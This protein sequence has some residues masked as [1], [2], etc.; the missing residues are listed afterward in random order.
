MQNILWLWS[1]CVSTDLSHILCSLLFCQFDELFSWVPL[2]NPRAGSQKYRTLPLCRKT[3]SKTLMIWGPARRVPPFRGFAD[4]LWFTL[5]RSAQAT[6]VSELTGCAD[7][8]SSRHLPS[9]YHLTPLLQHQTHLPKTH[10]HN[11]NNNIKCQ[12]SWVCCCY[13]DRV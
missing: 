1:R 13:H 11:W 3:P 12:Y 6:R 2:S 4:C 9:T 8:F 10:T 5:P 7:S